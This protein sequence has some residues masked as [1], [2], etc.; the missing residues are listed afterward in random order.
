M[1][2][3]IMQPYFLPYIGYFQLVKAVEKYVLYD[4]VQFIK[5]GWINRNNI[6][7][8]GNKYM[9][10][11]ILNGASSNKLI[12]EIS[13]S[14]NQTKLLKTI[15]NSYRRAPYF[16][17]VSSLI[18]R[19]FEYKESNLALFVGNSVFEVCH[20]LN[21]GTQIIYSSD[22]QKNNSLKGQEKVIS[23]CKLLEANTYFNAIGGQELY[24]K[25]AFKHENIDLLFLKSDVTH[26]SQFHDKFVPGLSILD[27]MM[28]N[29]IEEINLM[30]D[31]YEVL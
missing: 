27:V 29:S 31:Q 30:L 28:F 7:V 25:E 14:P 16:E 18:N 22:L 2:V 4:D 13:I 19:I 20:Y 9:F 26:Y 5:G 8:N 21:L 6:L 17:A 24:S 12:N 10:N 3:G 23:I 15:A 11:L 1:K